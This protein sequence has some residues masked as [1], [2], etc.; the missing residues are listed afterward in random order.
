[1]ADKDNTI[2]ESIDQILDKTDPMQRAIALLAT[3]VDTRMRQ[4]S[5]ENSEQHTH[6]LDKINGVIKDQEDYEERLLTAEHITHCPLGSDNDIKKLRD[7]LQP[8]LFITNYP[9]LAILMLVGVLALCGLGI[10]KITE[11]FK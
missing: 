10:D 7:E 1:M 2:L 8:Y 4:F 3:L 6:L 9:K 5:I 11:F